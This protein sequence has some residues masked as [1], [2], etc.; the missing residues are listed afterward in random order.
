MLTKIP[1]AFVFMKV[2]NHAGESLEAILARKQAEYEQAGRIFWGY[3]GSVCHPV[4]QVQPFARQHVG[5][6]GAIYLLMEYIDSKADP[7]LIPAQE[8]SV[9]GVIWQP[10]PEGVEVTG[11][12]YALVL[13]EVSPGDLEMPYKDYVVGVGPSR[14]KEAGQYLQGRVD[15]AC[16]ERN[17]VPTA[18]AEDVAAEARRISHSARLKEPYAVLLR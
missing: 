9:D 10:I 4:R 12:K 7:D 6:A 15:K 18:T 14:G 2:G 17:I 13:D 1:E 16:L 3:G 11:S 8:F 5:E